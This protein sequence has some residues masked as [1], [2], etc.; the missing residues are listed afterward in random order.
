[1][2]G[3]AAEIKK[4]GLTVSSF[5]VSNVEQ[6]LFDPG[7]WARWS[8]NVSAF[9]TD[10]KSLFIRAWLD[11]GK[12]HPQQLKGQRT[13]TLLQ[14]IA[15]FDERQAKKPYASWLAVA[16]DRVLGDSGAPL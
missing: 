12:S 3:V 1:M 4:R 14:R 11:Q 5:Y 9:P 15:D 13:A 16:T 7:V 6:Y 8:R 2:P 10:V